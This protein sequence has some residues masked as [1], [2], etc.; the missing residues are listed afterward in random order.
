VEIAAAAGE[1]SIAGK[2]KIVRAAMTILQRRSTKEGG[3]RVFAG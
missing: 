1:I 3:A 2:G